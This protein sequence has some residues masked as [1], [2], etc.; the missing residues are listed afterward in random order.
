VVVGA[1]IGYQNPPL[2]W[3]ITVR[4]FD[5]TSDAA[6]DPGTRKTSLNDMAC[7][8]LTVPELPLTIF[9]FFASYLDNSASISAWS[10][11]LLGPF[12]PDFAS[13]LIFSLLPP[14]ASGS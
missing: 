4:T 13:K 11:T 12:L 14:S 10:N 8:L 7:F 2:L 5:S 3:V 1:L 9:P 6:M